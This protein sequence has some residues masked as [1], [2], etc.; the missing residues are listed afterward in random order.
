[1]S[2]HRTQTPNALIRSPQVRAYLYRV[3]LSLGPLATAYGLLSAQEVI[4]WAGLAQ[5]VLALPV[6]V[7]LA[8]VP[9]P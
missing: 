7:A 9:K 1:M 5:T 8:N 6:G 2:R 4:L 3:V